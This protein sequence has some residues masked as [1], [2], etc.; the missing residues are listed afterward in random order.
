M[1]MKS[2]LFLLA[3]FLLSICSATAIMEPE[4][5]VRTFVVPEDRCQI[6]NP[7]QCS[8]GKCSLRYFMI[9]EWRVT[10]I[11]TPTPSSCFA[12]CREFVKDCETRCEKLALPLTVSSGDTCDC[13]REAPDFTV[14][15]NCLEECNRIPR[16]CIPKCLQDPTCPDFLFVPFSFSQVS[17]GT[18]RR[19]C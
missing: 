2:S 19:A 14:T 11:V 18:C 9:A 12:S 16:T 3:L 6:Q 1:N 15:A 4:A 8:N 5:I 10:W 7:N 17:D 13:Q